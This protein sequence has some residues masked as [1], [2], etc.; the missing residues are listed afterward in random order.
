MGHADTYLHQTWHPATDAQRAAAREQLYRLMASPVFSHSKRYPAFLRYVVERT[1]TG[2]AD[3]LKER[4]IGTDVFRRDPQ[5][6]TSAD[7]IVRVTA[8]EIR[9]RLAQYYYEPEHRQELRI[10]ISSGSYVP[11]FHLPEEVPAKPANGKIPNDYKL[12]H[13]EDKF[14]SGAVAEEIP[15]T[16][17]IGDENLAA[18]T[19]APAVPGRR[20]SARKWAPILIGGVLALLVGVSLAIRATRPSPAPHYEQFWNQVAK[21]DGPVQICFGAWVEQNPTAP[22]LPLA[23]VAFET[24]NAITDVLE[25]HNKSYMSLVRMLGPEP[26]DLAGFHGGP[27]IYFGPWQPMQTVMEGWR[28]HFVVGSGDSTVWIVDSQ[29][30]SR[31]LW[32]IIPDGVPRDELSESYSIA[33]RVI[34]HNM[35]RPIIVAAGTNRV[36]IGA[37]M[38]VFTNPDLL[39]DLLRD[40]PAGWQQMN[41]EAVVEAPMNNGKPGH[42]RIVAKHFWK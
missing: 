7:P 6:D 15:V 41:L 34:D 12:Q 27:I 36:G 17:S 5:Y 22:G 35:G 10:E 25:K 11:A 20:Q 2:H 37:A 32:R 30:P 28:Y 23:L 3:E 39:E 4:T 26:T 40:A 8:A 38:E 29:T 9:K 1:L 13:V 16:D 24:T 21:A 31:R 33:A 18:A 14:D 19:E 42:P